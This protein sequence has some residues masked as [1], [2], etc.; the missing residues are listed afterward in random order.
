MM[1]QKLFI[2]TEKKIKRTFSFDIDVS[3]SFNNNLSLIK[4]NK[5][6]VQ[7]IDF[8]T[9]NVSGLQIHVHTPSRNYR[10]GMYT[11]YKP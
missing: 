5:H 11:M 4:P 6:P 9:P 2:K 7:T 1:I 3:D 8:V 10:T